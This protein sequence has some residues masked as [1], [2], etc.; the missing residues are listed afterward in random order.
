MKTFFEKNTGED[1]LPP[2]LVSLAANELTNNLTVTINCSIRNSRVPNDAK[3]RQSALWIRGSQ[4]EQ[5]RGTFAQLVFSIPFLRYT[6]VLKQQLIKHLDNT[7]SV[8][9]AAYG[10][11]YGTQHFSELHA[12]GLDEDSLESLSILILKDENNVS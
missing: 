4:K 1:K 6:K 10:R 5:Y 9:I 8:F 11:A 12:Y 3:K 7:L 2:K